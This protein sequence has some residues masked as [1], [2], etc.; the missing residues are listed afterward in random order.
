MPDDVPRDLLSSHHQKPGE[1]GNNNNCFTTG[2]LL[3]QDGAL[4]ESEVCKS[5]QLRF[6]VQVLCIVLP[7]LKPKAAKVFHFEKKNGESS[8]ANC[9]MVYEAEATCQRLKAF[10]EN[11]KQNVFDRT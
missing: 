10:A 11:L 2:W 7:F 8:G 9:R 5:Y 1:G 3:T 4:N 6:R